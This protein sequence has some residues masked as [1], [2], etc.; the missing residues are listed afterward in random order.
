[1]MFYR[2]TRQCAV[3]LRVAALPLAIALTVS[4][5]SADGLNGAGG[6]IS[7]HADN[8]DEFYG[9]MAT[10]GGASDWWGEGWDSGANNGT[11]FV[12]STSMPNGFLQVASSS[13]LNSN[14]S[15]EATVI[16]S[17]G[18]HNISN[19]EHVEG[20]RWLITVDGGEWHPA[21]EEDGLGM[22]GFRV[23]L[24]ANNADSPSYAVVANG[25]NTL[26]IEADEDISANLGHDLL[27]VHVLD[28]VS[29]SEN[30]H[31]SFGEDRLD[32]LDLDNSNLGN[33]AIL[34]VGVASLAL[35]NYAQNHGALL[36]VEYLE[37]PELISSSGSQII[38]AKQVHIS[39][40]VTLNNFALNL[41][42]AKF[43]VDGDMQLQ[44]GAVITL[45]ENAIENVINIEVG[46]QITIDAG[47]SINARSYYNGSESRAEWLLERGGCHA[48]NN[49]YISMENDCA[50]GRYE[51]PN[52][53]GNNFDNYGWMPG[54]IHLKAQSVLLDGAIDASARY[55]ELASGGSVVVEASD[56]LGVGV[57][58]ANGS[59]DAYV[60]QGAGGRI[61]LKVD[62]LSGFTGST[63][64]YSGASSVPTDRSYMA[65][66]GTIFSKNAGQQ[67]GELTVNNNLNSINP[68]PLNGDKQY[69]YA[70]TPVRS[71]GK[72]AIIA[73][74]QVE[75]GLWAIDVDNAQW[76]ASEPEQRWGL[77]GLQVDLHAADAGIG[78]VLYTI[79]SN[80]ENRLY[81]RTNHD[82]TIYQN[83]ELVGVHTLDKLNVKNGGFVNFGDDRL[84][85]ND[86][87]GSDFGALGIISAG[88][89]SVELQQR[90]IDRG[91]GLVLHRG[92]LTM[93]GLALQNSV[94]VYGADNLVI[95]GDM[96]LSNSTLELA[97]PGTVTATGE[98]QLLNGSTITAATIIN[99]SLNGFN[100]VNIEISDNAFIDATSKID[101]DT[102]GRVFS[103]SN[104]E[105]F[106]E[107][108][109]GCYN[110]GG[111][112]YDDYTHAI[113][114]GSSYESGGYISLSADNLLLN[115]KLT[116]S[117]R[118]GVNS[119]TGGGIHVAA[120]N[121]Q[122]NGEIHADGYYA[123]GRV[124]QSISV[125]NSFS[126]NIT[127][128]GLAAG[129]IYAVDNAGPYGVLKVIGGGIQSWD[130]L[131]LWS[132]A[133][134]S[135]GQHT[136]SDIS[137]DSDKNQWAIK[138]PGAA[139]RDSAI[140]G[141][142]IADL[143]GLQVDLD[144]SD[145]AGTLY[146]IAANTE[147]TLYINTTD[148]LSGAGYLGKTVIGVHTLKGIEFKQG[149]TLDF[150]N[151]RLN[152]TTAPYI[153]G[154][155][156]GSIR[157]GQ[158]NE[159]LLNSLLAG[160]ASMDYAGELVLDQINLSPELPQFITAKKVTITGDAVFN[161]K[162]KITASES[163][164]AQGNVLLAAGTTALAS[165]NPVEIAGNLTLDS[166]STLTSK[167]A[168][169][170]KKIVYP[171]ALEVAGSVTINANAVI[172]VSGQGYPAGFYAPDFAE[173]YASACHGGA[174]KRFNSEIFDCVYG[175]YRSD[176]LA[177][178]GGTTDTGTGGGVVAIDSN[179]MTVNG[180]I[181]A[182]GRNG[183][184]GG[185]VNL[186]ASI[187]TG[188]G[189]F[190]V[191]GGIF[192][193]NYSHPGNDSIG[194]A[195]R[196]SVEADTYT[197][198]GEM[199]LGSNYSRCGYYYDGWHYYQ[200]YACTD[201]DA[202]AG[203][204]YI[205]LNNHLNG[206]LLVDNGGGV[207]GL[208]NGTPMP[209]VGQHVITEIS[210]LENNQ[211][212]VTV[213]GS[214]WSWAD[215]TLARGLA[216]TVV[217]LNISSPDNP[218]YE[219]VANS[220]NTLTIQL[221]SGDTTDLSGLMGSALIGVHS[222]ESIIVRGGAQM[223]FGNDRVL[224]TGDPALSGVTSSSHVTYG[225]SNLDLNNLRPVN[226][227]ITINF[228]DGVM[229]QG[230]KQAANAPASWKLSSSATYE[231]A[232]SLAANDDMVS[233][234]SFSMEW[235]HYFGNGT[236]R[237]N[238][239]T[240]IYGFY[241]GSN[242]AGDFYFFVDN[243]SQCWRYGTSDWSVCEINVTEGYHTL[244][245]R[246]TK[247]L[248]GYASNNVWID[249]FTFTPSPNQ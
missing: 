96:A 86:I 91:C 39:G 6:R 132:T 131:S 187:V 203:T 174:N 63:Q 5:V 95:Q 126:G 180:L 31:L 205:H 29:L 149:G 20:N 146:T 80:T 129:T 59:R 69:W 231:G 138:V 196:I 137:F 51:Q 9:G 81:I 65:G 232:Y 75:S 245:W 213:E 53:S 71:V 77:D 15:N 184:A 110:S 217:D 221:P 160:S 54:V 155:G 152:V 27:G 113:Y 135:V 211:W 233:N 118:P 215:E 236:I 13:W 90:I 229:P 188:N 70:K 214:P 206:N 218:L 246:Y 154:D 192:A 193:N 10:D 12:K 240:N 76:K 34:D 28:A 117:K 220:P 222:F 84:V 140:Y 106:N 105:S 147:D 1:M 115:G 40:D 52:F 24:D 57:I 175:N 247:G 112:N 2:Q 207:N 208:A 7:V 119:Y 107:C 111:V 176:L 33:G 100:P 172:D 130:S 219:I 83:D 141:S 109:G 37:L 58:S 22:V 157:F 197:F 66:A 182:D 189:V 60:V 242:Y 178:N 209:V 25:I 164:S 88:E 44:N 67:Y 177:G 226:E 244:L 97:A 61:A 191:L 169:S 14:S 43:V 151:D 168:D 198:N 195:G 230:W 18:R 46:N 32:I 227:A 166:G 202:A 116:A 45:P 237:F 73:I 199:M 47:A 235:R 249:N 212:L 239:K 228:N 89:M 49:N 216:G 19:I 11:V 148:D 50:Y 171:L 210:S 120:N 72:H 144:A 8:T 241:G 16:R 223:N 17:L 163:I 136:I 26:T 139:W 194:G 123:G 201:D 74:Q 92:T 62:D 243:N 36:R 104:G 156:T 128:N 179:S 159:E 98:M 64:A 153:T 200:Q 173:G 165:P 3:A 162:L 204:A 234:P 108:H 127:A 103:L 87:Y 101:Q 142:Y 78:D 38:H 21:T 122:G 124:S 170:N 248:Y 23:S 125:S 30:A 48:G 238:V 121:F 99:S 167:T 35:I 85:V 79:E 41:D 94:A 134:R 225:D 133:I 190:S 224:V 55:G 4:T 183:G 102:N 56:L 181:K 186:N 82:L 42:V 161:G 185:S 145:E 143:A 114:A 158:A 68:N 93:P 150:G